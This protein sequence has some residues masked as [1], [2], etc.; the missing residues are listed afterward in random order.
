M[1]KKDIC[2]CGN[3]LSLE[4]CCLPLINNQKIA[5]T[6]E[7]L[8]R[9][10]YTAYALGQIDYIAKTMAK[11]ALEGFNYENAVDDVRLFKW[12]KLDIINSSNESNYGVVEFKAWYRLDGKKY[13]LHEISQFELIDGIW[14]Y[15]DGKMIEG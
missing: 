14:F 3:A 6:P 10:R 15:V 7:L 2:K 13:L 12:L 4:S 8:M 11:N 1:A 5:T 9:S